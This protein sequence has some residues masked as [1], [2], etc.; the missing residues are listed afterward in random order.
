MRVTQ[1][2]QDAVESFLTQLPAPNSQECRVAEEQAQ[3][4]TPPHQ[5]LENGNTVLKINDM[6]Q[7]ISKYIY[8]IHSNSSYKISGETNFAM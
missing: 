1:I 2:L 4:S 6:L 7:C 5:S 3:R 8:K